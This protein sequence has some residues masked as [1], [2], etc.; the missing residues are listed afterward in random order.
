MHNPR[1]VITV[2]MW[3]FVVHIGHIFAMLLL[4][5]QCDSRF[6]VSATASQA[7]KNA[8]AERKA[9]YAG[10]VAERRMHGIIAYI[11][12][13]G[14]A[15][16]YG[17]AAREHAGRATYWAT[18]SFLV[19]G[20]SFAFYKMLPKTLQKDPTVVD[21]LYRSSAHDASSQVYVAAFIFALLTYVI[22]ALTIKK[23]P[24]SSAAK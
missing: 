15:V 12:A 3:F 20:V 6:I 14:L 17:V 5:A 2:G 1:V 19:F 21:Q 11:L 4:K 8:N 7:E 23:L 10:I 13:I 24:E 18:L 9:E 16:V 22:A